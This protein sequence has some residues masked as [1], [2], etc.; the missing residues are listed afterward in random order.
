MKRIDAIKSW[1]DGSMEAKADSSLWGK[2]GQLLFFK[3]GIDIVIEH[4]HLEGRY[5]FAARSERG[6]IF[7][8]TMYVKNKKEIDVFKKSGGKPIELGYPEYYFKNLLTKGLAVNPGGV[9]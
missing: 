7:F 6:G 8:N 1:I 2:V 3:G 5:G 4:C 9:S